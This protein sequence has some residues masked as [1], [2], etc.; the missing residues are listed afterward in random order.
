[1]P[2]TTLLGSYLGGQGSCS[3][4]RQAD[5]LIPN[6]SVGKDTDLDITGVNT[7]QAS[8]VTGAATTPGYALMRRFDEKMSKPG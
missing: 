4:A 2:S 5:I 7:L 3:D 1:M 8:L 6:R